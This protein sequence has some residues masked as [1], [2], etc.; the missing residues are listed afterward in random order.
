MVFMKIFGRNLD[1]MILIFGFISLFVN[2][3]VISLAVFFFTFGLV[4]LV[5]RFRR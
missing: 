1:R 2:I 5:N 3:L 4:V